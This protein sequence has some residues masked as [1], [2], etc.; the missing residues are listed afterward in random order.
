[1]RLKIALSAVPIFSLGLC[2]PASAEATKTLRV[3]LSPAVTGRFVVENLAGF[4]RVVPGD[5]NDVE[6]VATVHAESEELAASVR[7]EEVVGDKGLPTLR[8]RYPLDRHTHYRYPGG[9]KGSSWL[10]FFTGGSSFDYDRRRVRVSARSGVLLY[11]DVEVRLPRRSVQARFRNC[12]GH[13]EGR[14]VEG[15]LTFDTGSGRVTLRQVRGEVVADT[16]SGDVA[17]SG[18]EGSFR[19]DTGSGT[20][21]VEGFAG[22]DLTLDTGSG[23]VRA[24]SVRAERVVVD[25]GSGD[26]RVLDADMGELSIDT[27][28]GSVEVQAAGSKLV[29]VKADTGSGDV[30]LRLGPDASFEARADI[31]SGDLVNGYS[32]AQPI[33]KRREVIGYRRGDARTRILVDTGSGD[34]VLEP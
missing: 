21:D 15:A 30:R 33:L 17:A 23:K 14:E 28:S 6:A 8:V 16:G 25:T 4:M 22:A 32:D 13:M 18:I 2:V 34:V 9:E 24:A 1:V 5:G 26:V 3:Q 20:C 31:G 19:C 29:R 10:D 11:A 12:V 27:G 7:F